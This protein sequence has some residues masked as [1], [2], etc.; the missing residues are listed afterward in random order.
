[1]RD[2]GLIKALAD[3]IS[4]D[5]NFARDGSGRLFIYRNGVYLPD[6]ELRVKQAVKHCLE[7]HQKTKKWRPKLGGDVVEYIVLDAPELPAK[8]PEDSINVANGVVGVRTGSRKPHTPDLLTTVQLPVLFDP[9]AECPV[10]E[11]VVIRE[12]LGEDLG[13]PFWEALGDAATP[14]RSIPKALLAQ[15]EG[16][17]GKSL[18]LNCMT[19]FLGQA[20]VSHLSLQKLAKDRFAPARLYGKLANIC[21][22]LPGDHLTDTS[23]FKAITGCDRIT[24]EFKHKDSFE[25]SPFCRLIF[26]A[27]HIP[28]ARDGSLAYFDRWLILPFRR[29]FRNTDQEMPRALLDEMLCMPCELSGALNKALVAL[30]RLRKR[31]SFA[32]NEV[33]R[34]AFDEFR[35]STDPFLAWLDRGTETGEGLMIPQEDLLAAHRADCSTGNRPLMTSQ[36]FGGALKKHRPRLVNAQR[37][38]NGKRVWVYLGIGLAN[39]SS[40]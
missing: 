4:S 24:A 7:K 26:S 27:N 31:G 14:D 23:M 34:Q 25:F 37:R 39:G 40:S 38:I 35:A 33:T 36:A 12:V 6:G 16:G 11:E 15:G 13:D 5:E 9:T 2:V 1:M 17:N 21:P 30:R 18:V 32:Q 19:Q 29:R 20:N 28:Q 8:P 22:D 3:H 10:I